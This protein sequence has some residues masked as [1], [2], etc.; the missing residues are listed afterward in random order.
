GRLTGAEAE[1]EPPEKTG[2]AARYAVPLVGGTLSPH[3]GHCDEFALLDVDPS[4]KRIEAVRREKAP[5]H[6]PG[7]LPAWLA[8][9]GVHTIIAG[10]MGRR[11]QGLFADKGIDVVIGAPQAP[12]EEIV[13]AHLNGRLETGANLCDH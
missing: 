12:P 11:A 2:P 5:P 10:G 13:R 6:E 7:A 4:T 9:R 8:E 1:A 3:F